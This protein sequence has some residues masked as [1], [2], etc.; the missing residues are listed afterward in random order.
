MRYSILAMI[1]IPIIL[2]VENSEIHFSLCNKKA[3][4][5]EIT[6]ILV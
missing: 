2:N 3:L 4:I 6:I 5:D 1:I